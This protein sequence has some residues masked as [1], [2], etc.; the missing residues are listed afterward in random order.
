MCVCVC[1]CM[2]MCARG[3]CRYASLA[4]HLAD[5]T[6]MRPSEALQLLA[7]LQEYRDRLIAAAAPPV[8]PSLCA[9]QLELIAAYAAQSRL[10]WEACVANLHAADIEARQ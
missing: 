4:H 1:M 8:S 9:A 10:T 2:C 5:V 6:I 7:W 3:Q